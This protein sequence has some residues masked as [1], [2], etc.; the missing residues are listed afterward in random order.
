MPYALIGIDATVFTVF[1]ALGVKVTVCPV[2]GEEAFD[3]YKER[4]A[5]KWY[6]EREE[7]FEDYETFLATQPEITRVGNKF[8]KM[9]MADEQLEGGDDPTPVR[10][11]SS[12]LRIDAL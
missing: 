2:L 4:V 1:Q 7:D 9:K 5:E 11:H 12:L 8:H 3:E 10:K 6:E